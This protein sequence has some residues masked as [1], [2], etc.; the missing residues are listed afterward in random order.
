MLFVR[1]ILCKYNVVEDTQIDSST[2][3]DFSSLAG[4]SADVN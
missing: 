3:E 2:T 1:I 4:S